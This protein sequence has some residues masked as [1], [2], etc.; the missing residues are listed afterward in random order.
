MKCGKCGKKF[1]EEMYSGICPKCGYFNNRQADYDVSRY[2]SASFDDGGKASTSAQAAKQH[3]Q[4]HKMYDKHDMHSRN[5]TPNVQTAKPLPGYQ[6]TSAGERRVP[7]GKENPYQKTQ[8]VTPAKT[9]QTR[10]NSAYG[11]SGTYRAGSIGA[12]GHASY[13]KASTSGEKKKNFV[14]PLCIVI[15]VLAIAGTAAACQSKKQSLEKLYY[16]VEF[17]QETVQAGEPFEMNGRLIAA[18][19]VKEVDTSALEG[20]PQGEKLVA[21]TAEILPAEA[22]SDDNAS[23]SIYVWDGSSYKKPL[24]DYVILD[25]FYDGDY[26]AKADILSEYSF[27]GY[28]SADGKRGDCYFFV[29]EDA[30]ELTISFEEGSKKDGIYVL[31]RR[32]SIPLLLEEGGEN[33]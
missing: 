6:Q 33:E 28:I 11:Q 22:E 5:M 21:V 9:Y 7:L 30:E 27:Y 17:E 29:D 23:A 2:F 13:G 20:M 19:K 26:S 1:D 4:L 31:N 32:V 15:A 10:Q 8:A 16:T 18:E 12:Y 25:L 24:N 14:T 3:A